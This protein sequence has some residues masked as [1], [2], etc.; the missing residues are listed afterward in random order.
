MISLRFLP[1]E[2]WEAELRFYGC[3]PLVGQGP[4]N[5]A[6]FWQMPWQSY[7]FNVP[8]EEDGRMLQ[9]DLQELVLRIIGSA[10]PDTTFPYDA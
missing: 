8:V 10:P 5:T 1:R 2:E 9:V 7:P 3:K 6:E 4:L